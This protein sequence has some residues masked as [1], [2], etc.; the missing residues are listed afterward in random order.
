MAASGY[1]RKCRHVIRL[2][3]GG[4]RLA[5]HPGGG[6]RCDGSGERPASRAKQK[7]AK[8]GHKKTSQ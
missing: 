6:K 8:T 1:C 5:P 2:E 7:G 3:Q 4:R